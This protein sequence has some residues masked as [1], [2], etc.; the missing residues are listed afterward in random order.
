MVTKI[1]D[2][3]R[4]SSRV[5]VDQRLRAGLLGIAS[6]GATL[7]MTQLILPGT[8]GGGTPVAILFQ[9]LV[10]GL[11]NALTAV[12][13]VLIYRSHRIINFAQA[14]LGVADG[15]F[16]ANL[17]VLLGWNYFVAFAAGVLVAA[18]IG[19]IF[20]L[21]FVIRFY[22]APRLSLTI[23]TIAAVPAIQQATNY[24]NA[25]PIFPRLEDRTREQFQGQVTA[26][27]FDD[28]DFTLGSFGLKFG[29][30][31]LFA[32]G[33]TVLALAG[34]YAFFR[35]SRIGVAIRAAAENNERARVLGISVIALSMVAWTMSGALSG[36]G[37]ILQGTIQRQFTPGIIPPQLLVIP[38]AA[39]AITRFER[40]PMAVLGAVAITVLREAIR[41]SY[42]QHVALVDVGLLV[43]ILAIF[44]FTRR[45]SARSEESEASSFESANE[46]RPVP[47]ELRELPSITLTMRAL[48][49][50]GAVALIVFPLA[51]T[52]GQTNQ[53]AYLI[54][55][56]ISFLSLV[57]VTGWAGQ[58]SL[59]Q[60]AF[61]AIAA[62]VG[63]ALTARVGISFWFVLV[64]VPFFTAAVS[65]LMGFPALRIRGLFLAVATFALAIAV[66]SALFEERYFDWLLPGAVERPRLLFLDLEDTRSMYYFNLAWLAIAVFFVVVLRRSRM[67]RTLIALRENENNLRSFGVNP[68]RMRLAAFG[69]SGFLCGLAGVLLVHQ[70]RAATA[71]DFPSTLSLNIFLYAVVGGVGS[72]LGALLGALYFSLQQLI[73]NE[74][75]SLL[76]GPVGVLALLYI[77]PGGLASLLIGLRDGILKIVAQ[78]RQIVVPS[79]FADVDPAVLERRLIPLAESIPDAGLDILPAETRYTAGSDL[80]GERGRAPADAAVSRGHEAA[81]LG[82]AAKALADE[83]TP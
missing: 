58:A 26:L 54:L 70:Q 35:F 9:G 76:V 48:A 38:L 7:F 62:V 34:F 1:G 36:L 3:V 5:R 2:R 20:Q 29:F 37:V 11:L 47:R 46:Q 73:T 25:L 79:L 81:V 14:G 63:G 74:F 67:G 17:I 33:I 27:P 61:V 53:A 60:F 72:V 28:F 57:V 32:I 75:W 42:E 31:H 83:E 40:Y 68:T 30:S 18:G 16:T 64:L 78:R 51:A 21:A 45:Q 39:A 8:R 69:I 65:T 22:R 82:A 66:Q 77:A 23:L 50:I 4:F 24:I 71:A 15:V 19:L 41:F 55:V 13:I 44:L 6:V 12:G 49:L 52:P 59:G 10:L 43:L 80:Y 56:T